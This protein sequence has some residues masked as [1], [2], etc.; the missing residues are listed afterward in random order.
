MWGKWVQ[1]QNKTQT[2]LVTSE[3]KLYE[4]LT[5]SGTE[6]TN[7]IFPNDDV[8]WVSWKYTED[9]IPAGKNVNV[10]VDANVTTQAWLKLYEYLSELGSL[11][12]T[13]IRTLPTMFKM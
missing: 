8:V 3:K 6:V 2:T 5:S 4:L 1:N 11:C 9:N 7:V 13:V 10:T 12:C